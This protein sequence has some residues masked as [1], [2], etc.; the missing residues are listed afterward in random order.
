MSGSRRGGYVVNVFSIRPA[1]LFFRYRA[2]GNPY[3]GTIHPYLPNF[4]EPS[5]GVIF[6][7]GQSNCVMLCVL[8]PDVYIFNSAHGF[9]KP[10]NVC[11][12]ILPTRR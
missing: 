3:P 11:V 5:T 4:G 2:R 8:Y 12:E 6:F 9:D 10:V 7:A 1:M